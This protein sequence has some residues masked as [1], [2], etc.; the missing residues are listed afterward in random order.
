MD[1]ATDTTGT[2]IASC[3]DI[4]SRT[5]IASCTNQPIPLISGPLNG[6]CLQSAFEGGLDK[7]M[8]CVKSLPLTERQ[9]LLKILRDNIN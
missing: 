9:R 6:L 1:L 2:K 3:T 4:A 7:F 5:D 8:D